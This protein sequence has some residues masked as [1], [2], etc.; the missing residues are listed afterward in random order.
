MLGLKKASYVDMTDIQ[1]K[2]EHYLY[3]VSNLK[4][5]LAK[6]VVKPYLAFL[7]PILDIFYPST[8]GLR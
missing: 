2:K 1:T 5:P 8:V 4:R 7:V 6:E 3:S